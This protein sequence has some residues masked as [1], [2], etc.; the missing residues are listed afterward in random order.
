MASNHG[1]LGRSSR[2]TGL[3]ITSN[4][5]RRQRSAE[6]QNDRNY[7][8]SEEEN[9]RIC[10]R[11]QGEINHRKNSSNLP[12]SDTSILAQ[13]IAQSQQFSQSEYI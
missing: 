12:P 8:S 9:D 7:S 11:I 13:L 3:T 5:M 6:W 4:Q 2:G 1:T 10:G